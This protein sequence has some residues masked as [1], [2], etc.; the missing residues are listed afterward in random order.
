M[1]VLSAQVLWLEHARRG[2]CG[3]ARALLP[4]LTARQQCGRFRQFG[5]LIVG[6]GRAGV[7]RRGAGAGPAGECAAERRRNGSLRVLAV[8]SPGV[9]ALLF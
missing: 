6:A 2:S 7:L 8:R 4:L 1:F 9:V 5:L 3:F